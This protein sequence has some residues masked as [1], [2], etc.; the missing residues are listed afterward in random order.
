[1]TRQVRM[2]APGTEV[3]VAFAM[4]VTAVC[5]VACP[6]D[7]SAQVTRDSA[8]IRIV[9]N[10]RPAHDSRLPWRIDPEPAASIGDVFGAEAYLLHQADDATVLP[11]GRIARGLNPGRK[12]SN[13]LQGCTI[14]V[15]CRCTGPCWTVPPKRDY[16]T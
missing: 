9:E 7:A 12:S 4:F 15:S 2:I 1:M 13:Y 14:C 8:G 11:D 16:P 6:A 3:A 10:A 5:Q